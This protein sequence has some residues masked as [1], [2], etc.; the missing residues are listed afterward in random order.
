MKKAITVII[1]SLA[2]IAF[3][4]SCATE[5][6]EGDQI[7]VNQV[8]DNNEVFKQIYQANIM[9]VPKVNIVRYELGDPL[10]QLTISH[11]SGFILANN[12]IVTNYHVGQ[13]FQK[14][15]AH[16][17]PAKNIYYYQLEIVYP[18]SNTLSEDQ[19]FI[20][21]A[22]IVTGIY[23]L[24]EQDLA[25]LQVN[26]LSRKAVTLSATSY[27][28][29]QLLDPVMCLG[30]PQNLDFVPT[31]GEI[32]NFV[33]GY[34]PWIDS[35]TP[36]IEASAQIDMG[37]SGGPMFSNKGEVIGINFASES[38]AQ[39]SYYFALSAD[40]LKSIDLA[41]IS[42]S[43]A[44]LP[45]ANWQLISTTEGE[46]S[47]ANAADIAYLPFTMTAGEIYV[48]EV[49]PSTTNIPAYTD[50]LK[51]EIFSPFNWGNSEDVAEKNKLGYYCL[52][53]AT[54]YYY[55][56]SGPSSGYFHYILKTYQSL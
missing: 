12:V 51:I 49:S 26:T 41:N 30:Y 34:F 4:A 17:F 33:S 22:E 55:A 11:G 43:P 5:R 3:L 35:S 19:T 8:L 32:T 54:N 7:T 53:S 16:D 27:E 46:E 9:S 52:E 44:V 47:L 2:F 45:P 18:A 15:N 42:F 1:I 48:L 13:F 36:L 28:Q 14:Y 23:S 31:L 20:Y 38:T 6:K 40:L 56:I 24:P 50:D 25:L 39:S 37:N 10:S 29:L 21:P